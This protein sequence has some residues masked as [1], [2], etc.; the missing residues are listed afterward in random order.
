MMATEGIMGMVD[1]SNRK[2]PLAYSP[3]VFP[4]SL[5]AQIQTHHLLEAASRR[6]IQGDT[7]KHP[8]PQGVTA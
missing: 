3:S 8:V 1:A 4:L 7:R 2:I 6:V 5:S